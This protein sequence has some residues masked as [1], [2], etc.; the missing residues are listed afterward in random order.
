[1]SE[2]W[3]KLPACEGL[4]ENFVVM[5][6]RPPPAWVEKYGEAEF[7]VVDKSLDM[8][9]DFYRTKEDAERGREKVWK[10]SCMHEIAT[11]GIDETR[12]RLCEIFEIDREDAREMVFKAS[13]D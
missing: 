10:D 13:L 8:V 1:M 5:E 3:K 7:A 11:R 12:D 2:R 4:S 6:K 9:Y